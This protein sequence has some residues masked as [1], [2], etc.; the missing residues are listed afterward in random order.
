MLIRIFLRS[1][2]KEKNAEEYDSTCI[3]LKYASGLSV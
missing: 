1:I 3:N 2:K